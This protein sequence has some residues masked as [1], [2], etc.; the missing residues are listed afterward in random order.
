V[1]SLQGIFVDG[2]I[3]LKWI[4]KKNNVRVWDALMWLKMRSSD[5]E[6]GNEPTGFIKAGQIS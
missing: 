1:R 4:L 3:I 5:C 6:F 2:R